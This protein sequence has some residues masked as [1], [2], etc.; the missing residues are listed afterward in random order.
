MASSSLPLAR[1]GGRFNAETGMLL[2]GQDVDRAGDIAMQS[3]LHFLALLLF[4]NI[5][6]EPMSGFVRDS[7]TRNHCTIT[8]TGNL[9]FTINTG[10]GIFYDAAA[11]VDEF[12]LSRY[13]PIVVD[14]AINDTLAAHDA[15]NPRIDIVCLSP[16]WVDD[17][18]ASRNVKNP[19]TGVISATSVALRRRFG[20]THTIVTGTPAAEPSPPAV[21]AGSIEIAR[22][23][24]PAASGAAA[25]ADS[26]P[27]IQLGNY[28]Q[29]LP[30][31]VTSPHVLGSGTELEVSATSPASMYVSCNDGLADIDGIVRG[32]PQQRALIAAA[33]ATLPRIDV[34]Y[35]GSVNN[36]LNVV[37]G[38]PNASPTVP[39]LP[40]PALQTALAHV[41]VAATVTTITSGDI[42]DV[43]VRQPFDGDQLQDDVIVD[44]HIAAA[45]RRFT[46]GACSFVH[47]PLGSDDPAGSMVHLAADGGHYYIDPGSAVGNTVRAFAPLQ[48]PQGS[49]VTGVIVA[50]NTSGTNPA[51]VGAGLY[52]I[53]RTTGVRSTV[54]V[55]AGGFAGDA[56]L[57]TIPAVA[58]P[59]TVSISPSGAAAVI[60][61]ET[62]SYHLDVG[63]SWG[64]A[65]SI[66][67]YSAR[68]SVSTSQHLS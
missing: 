25:W 56:T 2:T 33:H 11:T 14:A 21:P 4:D 57:D 45:T 58:G 44:R 55:S 37:T 36:T 50:G 20:A 47:N 38:T 65:N 24:V 32:Y 12:G 40:T 62:Y 43:R 22:A 51:G 28:F 35:V 42:T 3:L 26:R 7:V 67:I 63:V 31:R 49:T 8:S 30:A 39:A 15:T 13:R 18:S 23:R 16:A 68:V 64:I 1:A 60:D 5:R 6:D 17:Q 9:T 41:A 48:L 53:H 52:R 46:L 34:V 27:P 29:G 61:N 66:E 10:W 19:G 54:G 59:F